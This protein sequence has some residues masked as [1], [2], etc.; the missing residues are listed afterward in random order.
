MDVIFA[1]KLGLLAVLVSIFRW[2]AHG[3][4]IWEDHVEMGDHVVQTGDTL[5][6]RGFNRVE[7][8]LLIQHGASVLVD[9]ARDALLIVSGIQVNGSLLIGNATH[10]YF[11]KAVV[12]FACNPT[13]PKSS[14]QR[15]GIVVRRGGWIGLFGKKGSSR[16][17]WTKLQDHAY[18]GTTALQFDVPEDWDIG[19]EISIASTDFDPHQT[20]KRTIR[21][22]DGNVVQVN[23][24]LEFTHF[25]RITENVDQRAEVAL[26][27]R[28]IVFQGCYEKNPAF[29]GVGGHLMIMQGFYRA[30]IQGVEFRNFG[31]A[32]K[33]GRYP[34]HFHV[35]G[36]A[37]NGTF[38]RY[39]AIHDS[40]FR[41]ITVHGTQNVIVQGNVAFNITGHA[42]M[43]EDGAESGN[44]FDNNCI[45]LV[46]EKTTGERLGSDSLIALSAFY[47]TNTNNTFT[48]NAVAAVEGSGFWI[49][50]RL[51][52][53][54]LSFATGMYDDVHP[55]LI[56]MKEIRNNSVHSL[57]VGLRIE[58]PDLDG[59]DVPRQINYSPPYTYMPLLIPSIDR[60]TVHHSREGGWFRIYRL[61][62]NEW[63]VSDCTE[64]IQVLAQGNTPTFVTEA[65][66]Q[67]S[68][69]VG[70]SSNR[71]NL[72]MTPWQTI[73]FIENRSDSAIDRSIG[74]RMGVKLYDGPL[75]IED[76]K[77]TN[78]VS[79]PCL[80]YYIP[81]IGARQY[82]TFA[83][84]TLTRSRNVTFEMTDYRYLITDRDSDGGKTTTMFDEDGAV[85]GYRGSTLLPHW[86]FYTTSQCREALSWRLVCP[87]RYVNVDVIALDIFQD[88]NRY[89]DLVVYRNNMNESSRMAPSLTFQG[90]YIPISNGWLYHPIVSPGASYTLCFSRMMPQQLSLLISWANATDEIEFLIIYPAGTYIS[91][92]TTQHGEL[93][94]PTIDLG[95]CRNCYSYDSSQ[96][97]LSIKVVQEYERSSQGAACPSDGCVTVN[98]FAIFSDST[99]VTKDAITRTLEKTKRVDTGASSWM[100]K[101]IKRRDEREQAQ[102]EISWCT[103]ADP[104]IE[105]VD[106]GN[107]RNGIMAYFDNECVG[108][109]CFT[110]SCRYCKLATSI[111]TVPFFPCPFEFQKANTR[112]NNASTSSMVVDT[113]P[114]INNDPGANPVDNTASNLHTPPPGPLAWNTHSRS[115]DKTCSVLVSPGDMLVGV[116]AINDSLC[117]HGGLGC[118]SLHCRY[119]K[120]RS[121]EQSNHFYS[122]ST[123]KILEGETGGA[124]N[125]SGDEPQDDCWKFTSRGDLK[126]GITCLTDARCRSGGLGCISESCRFCRVLNSTEASAYMECRQIIQTRKGS[127][128]DAQKVNKATTIDRCR[129]L[130]SSGDI[131]VGISAIWDETCKSGGLGCFSSECRFCATF[132][133]TQSTT[134]HDCTALKPIQSVGS[135][136]EASKALEQVSSNVVSPVDRCTR[137]GTIAQKKAGVYIVTDYSCSSAKVTQGD[138]HCLTS[139]CRQ[140]R[141]PGKR[142]HAAGLEVCPP[143]VEHYLVKRSANTSEECADVVSFADSR[144]GVSAQY[145]T[146]CSQN[147]T[148]SASVS[149][150]NCFATLPCRFCQFRETVRSKKLVRCSHR[151]TFHHVSSSNGIA[152]ANTT[153]WSRESG[154]EAKIDHQNA[155][156]QRVKGYTISNTNGKAGNGRA[157][158]RSI[159]LIV[160][161]LAVGCVVAGVAYKFRNYHAARHNQVFDLPT[162][163]GVDQQNCSAVCDENNAHVKL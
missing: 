58:S 29:T 163:A 149:H 142:T 66:I 130:V 140:C 28:S 86:D 61:I 10:P 159:S 123:E 126:A 63:I 40:N 55:Y 19:D 127:E 112:L 128:D 117:S 56:P 16:H 104:C 115:E 13:L 137:L 129:S 23:E 34:I 157:N 114:T 79:A 155:V 94:A 152:A 47:I 51:N 150:V 53:K 141:L 143:T 145:D 118:F 57:K 17:T 158:L 153:D 70:S 67:N 11:R 120:T 122:C 125:V 97:T 45:M 43:L 138:R 111:A 25:G 39:N 41:A 96:E 33:I 131:A 84:S 147:R 134:F 139:S 106:F 161:G 162:S 92:I 110:A 81:A 99:I 35:A 135:L 71:G 78:W 12:H 77:F 74:D 132:R 1:R 113:S 105:L 151:E 50:T 14:E 9:P 98:I 82:N 154:G 102:E 119:C 107:Y 108:L 54:G 85:T 136:K 7:G 42:F 8:L 121:T 26:L 146:K 5:V 18:R 4:T 75:F 160:C 93:L 133:S 31:Q 36:Y 24:P 37:P 48:G 2:R 30:Q 38:L 156:S 62:M 46:L 83:M 27:T 80:N 89:G 68:L 91:N 101:R 116:S 22:I 73:N 109:G 69:F 72:L 21:E 3:A 124:S 20:E 32:D 60:F 144:E 90:Q 65:F 103:L 44:T 88:K 49:H 87:H 6:L 15:K 76:T 148:A 52:V 100:Q 59:T 95:M 64:G